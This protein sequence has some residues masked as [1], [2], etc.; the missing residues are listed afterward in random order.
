ML[1][2]KPITLADLLL[3]RLLLA[4][5]EGLTRSEL[6]DA[7]EAIVASQLSTTVLYERIDQALMDLEEKGHAQQL[8]RAR[9]K[10]TD[11]GKEKILSQLQ[12]ETLPPRIQWQTLKNVDWI[13]YA[14]GLPALEKADRKILGQAE[15]LRATILQQYFR[16]PVEN[17]STLT[18]V[19]NAL[20]WQQLCDRNVAERLQEQL[21]Q[22]TEKSFN[23]G[24][25]MGLLLND[26]LQAPKQLPWEQALPQLIAKVI[27]AKRTA[28]DELRFAIL[29]QAISEQSSHSGE[30]TT[31]LDEDLTNTQTAL[32]LEEFAKTV[33]EAAENT[34]TGHFGTHR[35]FISHVWKTFQQQ[36]PETDCTLEAFKQRLIEANRQRLLTL[37]RADLGHTLDAEDTSNSEI[38]HLNRTFHFIRLD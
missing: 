34:Q 19:R 7:V 33:L 22:L 31:F 29:R 18:K 9:Y 20:L 14:L 2:L 27:D 24:A 11:N 8:G 16:L 25:V 5:D 10:V 23:Q 32:T 3:S 15:G 30:Q 35:V 28:P 37:S 36:H 12:L 6:K 38:I 1:S 4:K 17:F 21:P 26:L 13:S